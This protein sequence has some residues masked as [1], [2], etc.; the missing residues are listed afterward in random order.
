MRPHHSIASVLSPLAAKAGPILG[1][2]QTLYF[3][4]PLYEGGVCDRNTF[5]TGSTPS[6]TIGQL[7]PFAVKNFGKKV[8][9]LAA[10]YNYGQISAKWVRDF[11]TQAA[12]SS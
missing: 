6:Q 12:A 2:Y 8:Y 9:V 3:Y 1:R 11:T 4:S 5:L 10:D 7:M